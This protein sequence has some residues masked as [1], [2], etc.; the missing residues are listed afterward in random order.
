MAADD[1]VEFFGGT[2]RVKNIV[3]TGARDDSMDWVN[4]WQG[5]GQ[6]ILIKQYDDEGN[7]GIEA[8]NLKKNMAADH[9][10]TQLF[11]T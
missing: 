1:G 2:V 10:Q 8:D 3:I 9:V 7:N 4:G 6:F 5:K 11:Q